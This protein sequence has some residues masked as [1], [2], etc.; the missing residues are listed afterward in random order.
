M[1]FFHD[2]LEFA[3]DCFK[4]LIFLPPDLLRVR[5]M[6]RD[7][8]NVADF[9]VKPLDVCIKHLRLFGEPFRG[10]PPCSVVNKRTRFSHVTDIIE[11]D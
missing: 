3:L 6:M 5:T 8:E 1:A 11:L 2:V 9:N 7:A 4:H 10:V